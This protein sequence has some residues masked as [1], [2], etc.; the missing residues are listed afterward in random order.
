MKW[1]PTIFSETTQIFNSTLGILTTSFRHVNYNNTQYIR[2]NFPSLDD[3]IKYIL[4][5]IKI[6]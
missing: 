2:L 1:T 3:K 6:K 4:K 5:I